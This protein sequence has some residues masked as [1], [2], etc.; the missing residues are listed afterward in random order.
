MRIIAQPERRH[1]GLYCTLFVALALVIWG[2]SPSCVFGQTQLA[3]MY[4]RGWTTRDGA[5]ANINDV[6]QGP[7][8]FLWLPT[9]DGLF[10]FDGVTF[11]PYTSSD[12]SHLLSRHLENIFSTSDGNVWVTYIFGGV[13][14]IR[15]GK[16]VNFTESDGLRPGLTSGVSEGETSTVW[17]CS[18]GGLSSIRHNRITSYGKEEGF[19]AEGCRD[20]AIDSEGNLWLPM[21]GY[22]IVK[23][24]GAMR[25]IRVNVPGSSVTSEICVSSR[26]AGIWCAPIGY[27][28]VHIELVNGHPQIANAAGLPPVTNI[29]S[30]RDGFLWLCTEQHGVMRI[31]ETQALKAAYKVSSIESFGVPEGLTDPYAHAIIRDREGSIWIA[32]IRGLD[33]LLT[34]PFQPVILPGRSFVTPLIGNRTSQN[35]VAHGAII[36]VNTGRAVTSLSPEPLFAFFSGRSGKTWVGGISLWEY[37]KGRLVLKRQP[38]NMRFGA[39]RIQAI[40]EDDDG[41]LWISVI[42]N[43]LYRLDGAGWV[44]GSKLGLPAEAAVSAF[45]GRDGAAWFGFRG[46]RVARFKSGRT[47][48]YGVDKGLAVGDVKVFA[49]TKDSLLV[50]GELGVELLQKGTFRPLSLDGVLPIRD[51]TGLAISS[52]GDLWINSAS[53]AFRIPSSEFSMF[54]DGSSDKMKFRSFDFLD[55]LD[56]IPE[57]LGELGSAWFGPDGMLYIVTRE[58]LQR[59]DPLHLPMNPNVPEVWITD[60]DVDQQHFNVNSIHTPMKAFPAVVHFKYTATSLLIPERVRFRY[61][62]DGYDKEWTEAG[63]RREAFYSKL[64]PGTYTFR[65]LACND[66]GLWNTTP[67]ILTFTIPATF[68]QTIWFKI[69][70]ILAVGV[71]ALYLFKR[72]VDSIR[73]R[74]S[75]RLEAQVSER[76][77]I[78]R[79]LHDTFFQGIEGFLIHLH[80]ITSRLQFE[81]EAAERISSAFSEADAV[82]AQGRRMIFKLRTL[83]ESGDLPKAIKAFIDRAESSPELKFEVRVFG[84]PRQLVESACEEI[85]KIVR[86][87]IWNA[88]RHARGDYI[89]VTIH[90]SRAV[91]EICVED[92]GVGID[93]AV[94]ASGS[95]PGHWGLPGIRERAQ[96]LEA[97]LEIDKSA[98]GGAKVCLRVPS[99]KVYESRLRT[100]AARWFNKSEAA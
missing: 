22:L 2:G 21:P 79:D 87:G 93:P 69:V 73:Q 44:E 23:P 25:F 97:H 95:R 5:P 42:R 12:G 60:M 82:M 31:P 38:S 14:R 35:L 18:S 30:A 15:D 4:H 41:K 84:S 62:L 67:R 9:D 89:E 39:T 6:I 28:P 53:G 11:A 43:G 77:R 27:P 26:T 75:E 85:L 48:I 100:F 74:A 71:F 83:A 78:A 72:R 70:I 54:L 10:R 46:S 96:K 59:I 86:E 32:T 98:L 16:I 90:Y 19:P 34:T 56:G 7:D 17:I 47:E 66:S 13:S 88:I 58:H 65:V 92:N 63:T 55:G 61:Q 76:E 8:G 57:P 49:E 52:Q 29:L 40:T 68:T 80:V 64:P 50:G 20:P 94:Y 45:Q 81:P 51:V 33:Q 3:N 24:H 99:K 91:L 1:V 37:Q 36:D